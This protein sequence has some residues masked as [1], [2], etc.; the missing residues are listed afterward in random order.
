MVMANQ[1]VLDSD[2]AL[3]FDYRLC[4]LRVG[5]LIQLIFCEVH[6]SRYSIY[7]DTC[8]DVS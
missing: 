3:R 6:D 1:I 4:V 7:L 5:G 8:E 2:E